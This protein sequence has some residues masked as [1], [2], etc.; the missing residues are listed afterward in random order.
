MSK[1]QSVMITIYYQNLTISS[2]TL[3][4]H[5]ELLL[6][7]NA[8]HLVILQEM[9]GKF[10]YVA[11][12]LLRTLVVEI[13]STFLS[14]LLDLLSL[15]KLVV[16]VAAEYFAE[17]EGVVGCSQGDSLPGGLGQGVSTLL[18]TEAE[19]LLPQFD[20]QLLGRLRND[21]HLPVHLPLNEILAP[22]DH[23]QLRI[24]TAQ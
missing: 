14:F 1:Q 24:A 20:P 3:G 22:A 23:C 21:D 7:R 18:V 13:Q 5:V 15:G 11:L 4:G 2:Q 17:E 9:K 12:D 19:V 10:N 6:S 16:G 8:V